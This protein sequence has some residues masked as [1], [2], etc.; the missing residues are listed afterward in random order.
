MP[1]DLKFLKQSLAHD[2][3]YLKKCQDELAKDPPPKIKKMLK[4]IE[5]G[6]LQMIK[7]LKDQ[8]AKLEAERN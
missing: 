7:H 3:K 2:E 4:Q 8:I 1:L 6:H 5:A